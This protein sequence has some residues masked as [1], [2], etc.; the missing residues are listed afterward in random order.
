MTASVPLRP[1][2]GSLIHWVID[3][4]PAEEKLCGG[5]SVNTR[6]EFRS[7][8]QCTNDSRDQ[9]L[10]F[11]PEERLQQPRTIPGPH[12]TDDLDLVI[13]LRVIENGQ[14]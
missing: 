13:E 2:I 7:M 12:P 8:N 1:E 5:S 9:F 10:A 3:S 14:G 6:P 11:P 4:F